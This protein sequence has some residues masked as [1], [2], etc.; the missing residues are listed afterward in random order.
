EGAEPRAGGVQR[1]RYVVGARHVGRGEN[2]GLAE[3]LRDLRAR[4]RRTVEDGDAR[5]G[6]GQPRGGGAAEARGATGNDRTNGC[7]L[8]GGP[9]WVVM[10]SSK[11]S[12]MRT[13]YSA[14][15]RRRILCV[16]P[17]YARSVVLGGPSLSGCPE[18]YPDADVLHLGEMGDA[19]DR[20]IEYLDHHGGR[21]RHQLRYE[22]VERLPLAAFPTPAY[23][24]IRLREYF[25]AN[26]QFSS[27]C[28][29]A[30]EFCDIPALYG[31]NPRLKTAAQILDEL[32]VI[33]ATGATSVYFV[34]DNFIGNQK[35]AQELLPHLIEWQRRN[36]Y[37][38][39][40][41][42]EA[43]LNIAKNEKLLAQM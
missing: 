41:A 4:R 25:I 38:L 1:R 27:G 32:D 23:E 30:C 28:P 5:A 24:L 22:T 6:G 39:R 11:S 35:A 7:E 14:A 12:P 40:F 8:H 2:G 26:I 3:R 33:A 10:V 29:Y 9:P 18:Y 36:R 13:P 15:A 42:C 43:T 19:T 34:D 20:L 31:K 17:V 16:Y 21:P 37:P